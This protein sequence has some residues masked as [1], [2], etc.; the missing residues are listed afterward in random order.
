MR[1][2]VHVTPKRS[3]GTKGS[4]KGVYILSIFVLSP[5]EISIFGM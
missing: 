2:H 3:T 4:K 1:Q 5:L